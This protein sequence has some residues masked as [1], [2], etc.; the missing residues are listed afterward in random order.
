M[1]RSQVHFHTQEEEVQ[2][3]SSVEKNSIGEVYVA[4]V[5]GNHSALLYLYLDVVNLN[6]L[7]KKLKV[8]KDVIEKKEAKNAKH[9]SN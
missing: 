3:T 1:S 4:V 2:I 8:S 9:K 6:A 5:F 7:I